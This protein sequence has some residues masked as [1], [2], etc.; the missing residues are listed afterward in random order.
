MSE[1]ITNYSV[2]RRW[3]CQ[4]SGSVSFDFV[5]VG[6]EHETEVP[7]R[8]EP[9]PGQSKI[10]DSDAIARMDGHIGLYSKDHLRRV[11]VL[12]PISLDDI[13]QRL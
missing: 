1:R 7:C 8:L 9:L 4:R 10:Y 13:A 3:R 5:I 11:A 2:G 6:E 12:Q